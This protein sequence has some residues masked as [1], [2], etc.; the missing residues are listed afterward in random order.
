MSSKAEVAFEEIMRTIARVD[1]LNRQLK[2]MTGDFENLT[3]M[4]IEDF[5]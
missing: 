4:R 1:I 2:F 5:Y 3:G